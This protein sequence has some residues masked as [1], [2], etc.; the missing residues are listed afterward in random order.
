MQPAAQAPVPVPSPT[1]PITVIQSTPVPAQQPPVAVEL[2]SP[3]PVTM[4]QA[5]SITTEVAAPT[6][7]AIEQNPGQYIAV[8]RPSNAMQIPVRGPADTN[9]PPRS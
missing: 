7:S 5:A 1:P 6:L 8:N 4:Q 9:S 2:P 3:A